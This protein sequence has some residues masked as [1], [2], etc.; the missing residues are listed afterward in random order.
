MALTRQLRAEL[1]SLV[2][3]RRVDAVV[4]GQA[5][6]VLWR[7]EGHSA[8]EVAVLDAATGQVT[9][10][11]FP[12]RRGQEFLAFMKQVST[13]YP[14]RELHVVVDNLSTHTTDEVKA[15]LAQ[16]PRIVFH[17]TP[18]GSSWLNM[19]EIWFGIITRQA[20][21]RG[22]FTSVTRLT[23]AIN[24]YV[25]AWNTNAKPFV[26]PATPGEI[27]A[28]SAGST[29]RSANSSPTTSERSQLRDT[30]RSLRPARC[31]PRFRRTRYNKPRSNLEL[32]RHYPSCGL[33]TPPA[34]TIESASARSG[35]MATTVQEAVQDT[36]Q[37]AF[38]MQYQQQT[39][40]CW[41]ATATSVSLFYNPTS[42]WYQCY[43][44]NAE[45]GQSTCCSDGSAPRCN[46]PW[47]LDRA[48]NRVGNL[49]HWQVGALTMTAIRSEIDAGRPVGARI[50][51]SGGGA[52]FVVISGYLDYGTIYLAIQDPWYG[53]SFPSY[54]TF[55]TAYQ[56]TGTW[57][58][59]YFTRD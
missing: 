19:V 12:K 29:P 54:D 32:S 23:R 3:D 5:R 13:A 34:T 40:W 26:W 52:H 17:F 46:Q 51:W 21:R 1:S 4:A 41:S 27:L 20:I 6:M 8:E 47:Y 9:A 37:L 24:D 22:I 39:N 44:A 50:A 2:G 31:R 48:L 15:W 58:H 56:G 14:N 42:G 38:L 18:I 25:T 49:D 10:R 53:P 16:H 59:T 35:N 28:R 33:P 11:C 55:R 57:T 43:L 30:R 7:D 45:L 36:R